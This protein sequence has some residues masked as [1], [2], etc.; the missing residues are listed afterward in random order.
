MIN[1]KKLQEYQLKRL[2]K[3]TF[4]EIFKRKN[5]ID[6]DGAAP[7][8]KNITFA[9]YGFTIDIDLVG[10]CSYSELEKEI[11]YIQ[12]IFKA[13]EVNLK[14]VKGICRLCIYTDEL[15][16]RG[17]SRLEYEPYTCI[18]GHNYEGDITVD[19]RKTCHLIISGLSGTGK[20]C[21]VSMAIDQLEYSGANVIILNGYREDYPNFKGRFIIGE[22]I[23][24]F[25]VNLYTDIQ[26]HEKPLYVVIEEMQTLQD[27]VISDILKKILSVG[28]HYNIF[29]IGIIQEATKEN[30]KF[31]S[32]FNARCTFRQIDTSSIQ[33]VLGTNIEKKLKKQE[34]AL[35]SDDL[36]YGKTFII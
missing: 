28:R 25:L 10:I 22:D 32:L 7:K 24:K 1:I 8:V 18:L 14:V 30:C 34:F 26:Y 31:K 5:L 3:K 35:F 12:T 11:E 2:I 16:D 21:C 33:V 4:T 15:Q 20:S 17:Y 13:Y 27:K 36:Y 29:I 23:I 19:M 9:K 6:N